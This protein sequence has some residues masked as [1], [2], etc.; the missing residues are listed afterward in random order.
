MMDTSAQEFIRSFRN[1]LTSLCCAGAFV[2]Q[3]HVWGAFT[4]WVTEWIKEN[5]SEYLE[6]HFNDKDLRQ[7]MA[8]VMRTDRVIMASQLLT[9]SDPDQEIQDL[10][11]GEE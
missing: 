4:E 5:N 2:S 3:P 9:G 7:M 10:L 1:D 8:A 6:C 11:G